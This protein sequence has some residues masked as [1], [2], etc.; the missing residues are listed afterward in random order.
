MFFLTSGRERLVMVKRLVESVYHNDAYI[1]GD[2]IKFGQINLAF[3]RFTRNMIEEVAHI[4]HAK[5]PA[6]GRCSSP[7]EDG[8]GPCFDGPVVLVRRILILMIRFRMPT[9]TVVHSEDVFNFVGNFNLS[10]ITD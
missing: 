2:T 8:V 5:Q 4:T 1:R 10:I 7:V 6:V 3:Y 9:T